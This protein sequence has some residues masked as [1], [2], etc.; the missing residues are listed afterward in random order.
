MW[1]E[2]DGDDEPITVLI[3]YVIERTQFK[4]FKYTCVIFSSINIGNNRE[5]N[6]L[7][8]RVL[9]KCVTEFKR[10]TKYKVLL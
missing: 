9:Y 2:T 1:T 5:N 8:W 4:S 10:Q 7:P 3:N 6:A